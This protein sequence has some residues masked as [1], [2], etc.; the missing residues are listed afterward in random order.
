M[1]ANRFGWFLLFLLGSAV[2][3]LPAHQSDADH[4]LRADIRAKAEKGD[5]ESKNELGAKFFLGRLGVAKDEVEA[6][7]WF[8]TMSGEPVTRSWVP[9]GESYGAAS[10]MAALR[11][12]PRGMR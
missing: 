10:K 6:A 3:R 2:Y 4:K 7:K 1:K 11:V 5:A 9:V 12:S 8:R